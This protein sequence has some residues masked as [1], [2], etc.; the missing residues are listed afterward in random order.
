MKNFLILSIAL[1]T[2][3]VFS[4]RPDTSG[5]VGEERSILSS[6]SGTWKLTKVTQTDE[7]AK[8]KGFPY[9]TM[10]LT[11]LFPYSDFQLTLNAANGAPADFITTPGS[12]PKII[13]LTTGSWKVDD[14]AFPKDITFTSGSTDEIVILGGYPVA[15]SEKLVLRK[16]KKTDQV[17]YRFLITMNL[18]NNKITERM[19]KVFTLLAGIFISVF[20]FGQVTI[21]PSSFTAEDEITVT[22]DVSNP[23]IGKTL[24]GATEAYLWIF[25]N[26]DIGGGKDGITNGAWSSSSD[27]AK[28]TSLGNNKW[29]FKFIATAM[30]GQSPGELKTFGFLLK[31]KDGSKQTGDF[32]PF[33]FDPLVFVPTMLRIFPAKA[34]VDDVIT[35]NFDRTYAVT[36]DEQRMTPVSATVTIFDDAGNQVGQPLTI[37]AKKVN[38]TTWSAAMIPTRSFTAPAGKSSPNSN[39]NLMVL[40]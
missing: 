25:S 18:L 22:V 38:E 27:G 12:S 37:N 39:I 2:V 32:K 30:F 10:D 9:Q 8:R 36:V 33:T 31:S 20:S 23:D 6:L 21:S 35:L 40:F 3:L 13:N 17:R 16:E 1:I 11:T 5:I 19:K 24:I 7:D 4:C 15:G 14:P 28:V 26:P 34:D 29:Q